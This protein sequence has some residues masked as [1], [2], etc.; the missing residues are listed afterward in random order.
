[1]NANLKKTGSSASVVLD[2][3]NQ[4]PVLRFPLLD[5][6]GAELL[7][8]AD[9]L[10]EYIKNHPDAARAIEGME[11]TVVIYL[12]PEQE[13]FHIQRAHGGLLITDHFTSRSRPVGNGLIL[14]FTADGCE[15]SNLLQD[16]KTSLEQ[17]L[18]HSVDLDSIYAS[19]AG[20]APHIHKD[21]NCGCFACKRRFQGHEVV[22]F[23]PESHG[24]KTALCPYCEL[25]AV[26]SEKTLPAGLSCSDELLALMNVSYFNGWES[27]DQ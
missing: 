22:R 19:A 18:G 14:C 16:A 12:E 9:V 17:S 11:Q 13:E 10:A 25:D 21:T 26:L 3:P 8:R 15:I 27:M 4:S 24:S 23:I 20:N 7:A 6:T 2:L 1:M 5:D